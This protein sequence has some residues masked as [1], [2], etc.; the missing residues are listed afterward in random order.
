MLS[1]LKSFGP[2]GALKGCRDGVAANL[3]SA[4][5][6]PFNEL[7]GLHMLLPVLE[8]LF[9][10][11]G[12]ACSPTMRH[13]SSPQ[14]NAVRFWGG[15]AGG[16]CKGLSGCACWQNGLQQCCMP[17]QMQQ[18]QLAWLLP[19]QAGLQHPCRHAAILRM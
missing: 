16:A 4:Q 13:P 18:G 11:V 5:G 2:S 15:R 6:K 12:G 19:S 1:A 3:I 7:A 8:Q 9:E 14:V 10:V 17:C